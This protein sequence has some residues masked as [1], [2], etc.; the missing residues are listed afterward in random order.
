MIA[1]SI[2]PY[3]ACQADGSEYHGK[4]V[5][6]MSS[7][8]LTEWHRPRMMALV[9]AGVDFLAIETIPSLKEALAIITLLRTYPNTRAWITFSCKVRIVFPCSTLRVNSC[10]FL[11][12]LLYLGFSKRYVGQAG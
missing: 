2:G 10:T 11:Y 5:S 4:Y 3:G 12:L 1:G 7:E 9:K 6:D 8:E